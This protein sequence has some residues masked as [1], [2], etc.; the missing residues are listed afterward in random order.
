MKCLLDPCIGSQSLREPMLYPPYNNWYMLQ[1]L[2]HVLLYY[3]YQLLHI[4]YIGY[5]S[6]NISPWFSV[7]Y[8]VVS[9]KNLSPLFCYLFEKKKIMILKDTVSLYKCF[10]LL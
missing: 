10:K 6:T 1:I 8:S 2:L 5:L 4:T 9:F 7:F 3:T